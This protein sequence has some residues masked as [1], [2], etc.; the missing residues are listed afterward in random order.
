MHWPQDL[1]SRSWLACEPALNCLREGFVA[2]RYWRQSVGSLL[3]QLP[4][5]ISPRNRR[6][7]SFFLPGQRGGDQR[8]RTQRSLDHDHGFTQVDDNPIAAGKHRPHGFGAGRVGKQ[9][10]RTARRL[11]QNLGKQAAVMRWVAAVGA[12]GKHRQLW[13][14]GCDCGPVHS[15]IDPESAPG[16]NRPT[17]PVGGFDQRFAGRCEP[18]VRGPTSDNRQ[19]R[20]RWQVTGQKHRTLAPQAKLVGRNLASAVHTGQI[21]TSPAVLHASG[22][23]QKTLHTHRSPVGRRSLYVGGSVLAAKF[24]PPV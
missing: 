20:C 18:S 3:Q 22:A 19:P 11:A 1:L 13:H 17:E 5:A 4:A 9:D 14:P 6:Q 2:C 15:S 10:P 21:G 7:L 8:A 16:D 23:L 24:P 12:T